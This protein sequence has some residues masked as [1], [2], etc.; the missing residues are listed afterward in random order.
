ME[1]MKKGFGS[2]R[3]EV[4]RKNLKAKLNLRKDNLT[5]DSFPFETYMENFI[6]IKE[7]NKTIDVLANSTFG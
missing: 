5:R 7:I 4:E 3:P 2:T 1:T 6:K